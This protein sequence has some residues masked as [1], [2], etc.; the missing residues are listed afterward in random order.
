M[1]GSASDPYQQCLGVHT[2]NS[3]VESKKRIIFLGS[4]AQLF[5]LTW[6]DKMYFSSTTLA[7]QKTTNY[8][9]IPNER[10]AETQK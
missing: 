4:L 9:Y 8:V 1:L 6:S 2:Q 10:T 7:T 3:R 5:N